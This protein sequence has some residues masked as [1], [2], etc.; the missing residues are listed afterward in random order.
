MANNGFH[1]VD[2]VLFSLT[3]ATSLAI[4]VYYSCT[5]GKQRTTQEFFVA[6]RKLS[7]IP[8]AF[9]LFMSYISAVLVLGNTAEVYTAGIQYWLASVG[10]CL[11]FTVSALVFVPFFYN[12]QLTSSFEV[13][14]VV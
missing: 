1:A 10:S 12:L 9:S 4:G 13:G 7:A 2:F 8:V 14:T 6:D 11:A 3:L 5:G